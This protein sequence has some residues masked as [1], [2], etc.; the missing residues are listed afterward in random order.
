MQL[1]ATEMH[2]M[3]TMMTWVPATLALGAV[4]VIVVLFKVLMLTL[5]TIFMLVTTATG[6]RWW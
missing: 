2:V 6:R 1:N 5:V 4:A 3:P